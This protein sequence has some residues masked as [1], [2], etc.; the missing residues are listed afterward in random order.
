MAYEPKPVDTTSVTLTPEVLALT[1]ML[2]RNTHDI[3]ARQR[4]SEDWR[5]GPQRDDVR[6]EHPLLV[7]YEELSE[8]EK[9]YDRNTAL[10]TLKLILALGYRISPPPRANEET[11]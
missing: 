8:T 4:M 6:K 10:E 2:A 5:Y 7:P 3:W 9:Q 11:P 1:E